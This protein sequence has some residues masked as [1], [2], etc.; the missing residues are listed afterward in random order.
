MLAHMN[1]IGHTV[2]ASHL[3]CFNKKENTHVNQTMPLQQC[4]NREAKYAI[5]HLFKKMSDCTCKNCQIHDRVQYIAGGLPSCH[6][7]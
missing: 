3:L 1:K 6:K 2:H 7:L 5:L 4:T